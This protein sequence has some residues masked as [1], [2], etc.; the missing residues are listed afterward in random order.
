MNEPLAMALR[1]SP[2]VGALEVGFIRE[3]LVLYAEDLFLKDPGLSLCAVFHILDTF[4]VF[5][6]LRVNWDK[7]TILPLDPGTEAAVD[8]TMQLQWVS[9]FTYLR[10]PPNCYWTFLKGRLRP[11][12][13]F[14]CQCWGASSSSK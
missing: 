14:H 9:Q 11:G 4:V 1:S 8:A 12:S 3:C 5:S 7:P 2:E 6:G 10:A 13:T